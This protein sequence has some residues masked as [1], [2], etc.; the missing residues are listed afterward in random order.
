LRGGIARLAVGI[1]EG[2]SPGSGLVQTLANL[3]KKPET[4]KQKKTFFCFVGIRYIGPINQQSHGR[5]AMNDMFAELGI[6]GLD[7]VQMELVGAD[8]NAFSILGRFR[9][10]ARRQGWDDES[11]QR[12]LTRAR[13]GD[14]DNLLRTIMG[15]T[16]DIGEDE[17]DWDE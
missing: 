1:P 7:P 13:S 15:V 3:P 11:I 5:N 16:I 14:Y 6:T 17:D 4:K 10:D 9:R 8:G 2:G 12:V